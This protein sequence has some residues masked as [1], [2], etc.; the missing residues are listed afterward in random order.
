MSYSVQDLVTINLKYGTSVKPLKTLAFAQIIA[1]VLFQS[2]Q[3]I[4]L[5]A[6]IENI[7]EIIGTK[8]ISKELVSSGIEY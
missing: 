6:I 2:S 8:K 4:N 1:N 5:K 7:P 3:P